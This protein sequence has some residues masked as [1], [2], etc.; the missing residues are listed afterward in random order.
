MRPIFVTATGTEIGK[1]YLTAALA[2]HCRARGEAVAVLKPVLSGFA[3]EEAAA[4][5]P[6]L[7]L[8]ALGRP[9]S[10]E[11]I[12]R[13]SPWRYRAPLAP[14]LAAQLEGRTLDFTALV[15][16]CQ[17]EA[18]AANGML[19]CEG[20]GGL[21]V[22]LDNQRTV[23]DWIAALGWP[24]LLVT[25]SYLGT[26]SHTLTAIEVARTRGLRIAAV[27]V[28]ETEGS[29]VGLDATVNTIARYCASPVLALP[30]NAGDDPPVVERIMGRL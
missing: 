16:F 25:G 1:T 14:N 4:S 12:E 7:L 18:A 6:G 23:L 11:A 20:I 24:L 10:L 29:T 27:V 3:P 22:P 13:I 15:R 8:A 9:A 21:M 2:R 17:D 30:R 26:M 5:D 19:L 28:N